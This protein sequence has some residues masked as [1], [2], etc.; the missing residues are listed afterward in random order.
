MRLA[1]NIDYVVLAFYFALMLGI[2]VYF[3]KF[4]KS[5]RDYFAGGNRIPWWVSG[6]SLYMTNFSAWTFTAAAGF[7]YHS[8]W[9]GVIYISSGIITYFVG[10]F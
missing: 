9:Y 4:S 10:H 8:S 7:I 5:V 1:Q 2:G 3:S 6:I